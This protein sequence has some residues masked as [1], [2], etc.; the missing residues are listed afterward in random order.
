MVSTNL[1]RYVDLAAP[2]CPVCV[3]ALDTYHRIRGW[4][5]LNQVYKTRSAN[6]NNKKT[7]INFTV[8]KINK[9]LY[10]MFCVLGRS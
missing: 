5:S 2:I 4:E 7:F 1:D 10:I 3:E 8:I 6:I 9:S